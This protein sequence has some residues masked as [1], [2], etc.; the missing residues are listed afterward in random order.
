MAYEIFNAERECFS[1][2]TLITQVRKLKQKKLWNGFS[3]VVVINQVLIEKDLHSED[4]IHGFSKI[5]DWVLDSRRFV[6][7]CESKEYDSLQMAQQVALAG[8]DEIV[9][10]LEFGLEA[11]FGNSLGTMKNETLYSKEVL[12]GKSKREVENEELELPKADVSSDITVQAE[13]SAE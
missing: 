10:V 9:K 11:A 3:T 8:K 7:Y 13:T 5:V 2:W 1:I 6:D 4:F 12:Y